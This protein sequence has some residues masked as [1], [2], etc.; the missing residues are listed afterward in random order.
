M[1]GDE[2][3]NEPDEVNLFTLYINH[4]IIYFKIIL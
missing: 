2:Y 4:H 1:W 3:I